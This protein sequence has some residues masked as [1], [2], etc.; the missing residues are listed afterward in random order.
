[1]KRIWI[2]I[3]KWHALIIVAG[4]LVWSMVSIATRRIAVAPPGTIVIR[5]GHYQLEPMVREAIDEM[6]GRYAKMR[7][8]RDGK[9]VNEQGRFNR[10]DSTGKFFLFLNFSFYFPVESS[11]LNL[12]CSKRRR[13]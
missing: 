6:A 1:M 7:L 10:E 3:K 9:K 8:E 13:A 11:L 5:M 12:P 2:F 4:A